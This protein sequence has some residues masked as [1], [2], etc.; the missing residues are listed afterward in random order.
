MSRKNLFSV[1]AEGFAELQFG[2]SPFSLAK[3][4]ISNSFDEDSVEHCSVT[5]E[6]RGHEL[7]HLVFED[8]GT[9]FSSIEDSWTL[10]RTTYKRELPDKRG[11][12]NLGE[13]EILSVASKAIVESAGWRVTFSKEDGRKVGRIKNPRLGTKLEL[14]VNWSKAEVENLLG[15]LKR[16][17]PPTRVAYQVNG[18]IVKTRTV[19]RRIEHVA[20]ETILLDRSTVPAM[21]RPTQ[22]QTDLLIYP[23]YESEESMLFEL[24]IPVQPID[25]PFHV[26][27]QQK[28]P[29]NPNRDAV[30]NSWLQDVYAEVLNAVV[31]DLTETQVSEKWIRIGLEDARS[32]TEV[33]DKIRIKRYGQ[34]ALLWS[35]DTEA[36]E[37]AVGQGYVLIHPKTLSQAERAKFEDSGLQHSSDVFG[38]E[39][40]DYK[41]IEAT[42][43]MAH[44]RDFVIALS[45]EFVKRGLLKV[46]VSVQFYYLFGDSACARG[47]G[48]TVAFNTAR[49]GKAWFERGI[50]PDVIGIAV[51]E[52]AHKTD[53]PDYAHGPAWQRTFENM[54]GYLPEIALQR[55][56]LFK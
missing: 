53:D 33:A 7:A 43:G 32:T 41:I 29:M 12:F 36:N 40:S 2:R 49:L 16:I 47:N 28:V 35:S 46:P 34:K 50:A 48:L 18:E 45:Q 44:V 4:P 20:L 38:S 25:C 37:R 26:D 5:V 11:R 10:F 39:P 42:Q 17:N 8:D 21:M 54:I 1:D 22:R 56:E 13:K 15:D 27:V 51:H 6:K 19:W 55:E 31:D 3:E 30:K 9:G 14:W 24:G 23:A 52:L